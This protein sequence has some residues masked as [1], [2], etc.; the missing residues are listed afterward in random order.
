MPT[1]DAAPRDLPPPVSDEAAKQALRVVDAS[2]AADEVMAGYETYAQKIETMGD[3]RATSHAVAEAYR[4]AARARRED[5]RTAVAR[6]Y[7]SVFS[8]KEMSAIADFDVSTGAQNQANQLFTTVQG[9]I[10]KDYAR[11]LVSLAH[12]AFCAKGACNEAADVQR[13]WRAADPRDTSRIDIPQ[14]V[15]QPSA[16]A[17]DRARPR[18]AGLVGLTGVARLS[19]R[20]ADKGRLI[21]CAVDEEA[22]AGLGYGAAALTVTPAYRLNPIQQMASGVGRKVTVRV[23]FPGPEQPEPL[24]LKAGSSR[25]VALARQVA[26]GDGVAQKSQLETELQIADLATNPPKTVDKTVYD[27]ALEAYRAGA[28]QAL[29]DYLE[30]SVANISTA[31]TDAALE[32]RAAFVATPAGK[33]M[34]DRNKE[35]AIAYATAQG[36]VAIRI[37]ADA[38]SAFCAGRDCPEPPPP[39]QPNVAKTEPSARK[40]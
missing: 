18:V 4:Q 36:A 31:Y 8:D 40:P 11:N 9:E 20:L 10:Q 26:E 15:S 6:A 12:A 37:L 34:H 21:D 7:A 28:K 19:C 32:A 27:A 29:A 13:V 14:W 24:R 25:A 35:L 17:L 22:P 38:R 30:L 1:D 16:A 23:G 3:D 33:A 2:K 39:A 5:I